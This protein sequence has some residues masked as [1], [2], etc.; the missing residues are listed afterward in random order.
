MSGRRISSLSATAE[1]YVDGGRER[2]GPPDEPDAGRARSRQPRH[3]TS[4]HICDGEVAVG[5]GLVCGG[6]ELGSVAEG[7]GV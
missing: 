5:A 6:C 7:V 4:R 1:D 3:T 2:A